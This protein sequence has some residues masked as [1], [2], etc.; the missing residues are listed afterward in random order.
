[1]LLKFIEVIHQR[2]VTHELEVKARSQSFD[3]VARNYACR[4]VT[5]I[6]NLLSCGGGV[7]FYVAKVRDKHCPRLR[8]T[9]C[10]GI[11]PSPSSGDD[12]L[13]VGDSGGVRLRGRRG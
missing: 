4:L 1:M 12:L 8:V 13:L 10:A 5:L 11:G 2:N 7:A 6:H 3:L 9:R